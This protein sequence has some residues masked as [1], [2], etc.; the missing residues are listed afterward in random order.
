MQISFEELYALPLPVIRQILPGWVAAHLA[1]ETLRPDAERGLLE[2]FRSVDDPTL[3]QLRTTFFGA[4][5][6][7]RFHP[8]D[9]TA[10]ALTRMFMGILVQADPIVH[11][12][13][14]QRFVSD[15]PRRRFMVCN[16]LSYTDTQVT[17][18]VLSTAGFEAVANRIVAIAGPK[19][20][21]DPWRRL[22]AI[23]LHTRKTPQSNVVATEQDALSPRELAT[24]A[25]AAID[26]CISLCDQGYIPL[27]Y[28]EGA[29]SRSGHMRPF[30]RASARYLAQAD[31]QILPV[32]QTGTQHIFPIGETI[33]NR[34][35]VRLAFGEP[36]NAADYPGK[37]GPIVESFRRVAAILP[38]GYAPDPADGE[39]I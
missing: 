26:D 11:P 6:T 31:V 36:F 29:R 17:D 5:D 21:T 14:L 33:M 19:V 13:H 28:P 27:L 38:E 7:W 12:E 4:G 30:L 32:A 9:P 22:A 39:L 25:F 16:H 3:Q 23:S 34:G 8:A 15:G 20:Y 2:L 1:D 18:Q 35:P 24:I 10:R 37:T